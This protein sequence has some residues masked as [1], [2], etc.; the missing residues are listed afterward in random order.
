MT[1]EA[2]DRRSEHSEGIRRASDG[3]DLE[4]IEVSGSILAQRIKTYERGGANVLLFGSAMEGGLSRN[5]TT[6]TCKV[7]QPSQLQSRLDPSE[8]SRCQNGNRTVNDRLR[9]MGEDGE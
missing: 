9:V 3:E 2:G 7:P 6:S 8:K 5:P 1:E 4:G